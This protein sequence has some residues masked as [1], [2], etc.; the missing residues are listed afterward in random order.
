[1]LTPACLPASGPAAADAAARTP[2]PKLTKLDIACP[3]KQ[4]VFGTRGHYRA[5]L[6]EQKSLN[7][8]EFREIARKPP[9]D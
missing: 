7:A 2:F 5:I 8:D 6:V 3:I 1:M 4:M 9:P